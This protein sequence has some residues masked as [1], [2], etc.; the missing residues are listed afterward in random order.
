MCLSLGEEFIAT[1]QIATDEVLTKTSSAAC[2][3]RANWNTSLLL[4]GVWQL[5]FVQQDHIGPTT[6]STFRTQIVDA[7]F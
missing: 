4:E 7:A 2:C 6:L 3:P 1:I 5:E